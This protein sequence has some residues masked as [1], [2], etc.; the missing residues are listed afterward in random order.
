MRTEFF[1]IYLFLIFLRKMFVLIITHSVSV[2]SFPDVLDGIKYIVFL[3]SI[4]FDV[5]SCVFDTV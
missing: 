2:L 5:F 4:V 1:T 3:Y